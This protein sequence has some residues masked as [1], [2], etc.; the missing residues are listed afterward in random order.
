MPAFMSAFLLKYGPQTGFMGMANSYLFEDA[1]I[2][3]VWFTSDTMLWVLGALA[4]LEFALMHQTDARTF[5]REFE[6][7]PKA[8]M[9]ALTFAGTSGAIEPTLVSQAQS[10][11]SNE[12]LSI[13]PAL[14]IGAVAFWAAGLNRRSKEAL[15]Q[16]DE[17]DDLG[18]QKLIY[19]AEDVWALFGPLVLLLY[20][21]LIL[22]LTGIVLALLYWFKRRVVAKEEKSKIACANCSELIYS[23]ALA[24]QN[25]N[26]SNQHPSAIGFFGQTKVK[27]VKSGDEHAYKLVEK[28]RC[29]VC[30]N[31]FQEHHVYQSCSACGHELM[32]DDRFATKYVRR[33]DRR[34][35]KVLV[36]SFLLSL[37]PIIGLIPA[38]IY[39]RIQLVAPFRLYIPRM[40][41]IG[42]RWGLRIFHFVLIAFQWVPAF[43]GFVAPIMAFTSYRMYRGSFRKR[44]LSK[45]MDIAGHD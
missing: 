2:S 25:C 7:Y 18:V 42:L 39:Y 33:I 1:N 40:R 19:Y 14:V 30:A 6:E 12:T 17:E 37:I 4:I 31:R 32:Q 9:A 24:C 41:N 16:S 43:G 5:L 44:L 23:T 36:I 29:P 10:L 38:I 27:P 15:Y 8:A 26:Q 45:S 22:I 35:P 13:I 21:V 20:P 11:L 28:K 34:V 3:S